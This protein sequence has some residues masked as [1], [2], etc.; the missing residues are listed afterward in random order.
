MNVPSRVK[1]ALVTDVAP[2]SASA[3]AGVS[4]GDVILEI[5][6]QRVISAEEAI[7]LSAKAE[8]KKTL[9]KLW[10]HGGTIFV[11]VD[12]SEPAKDNP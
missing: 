3:K 1:G 2:D 12:E 8:G 11:V 10:S 5:N 7:N 6:R 4:A 9:L